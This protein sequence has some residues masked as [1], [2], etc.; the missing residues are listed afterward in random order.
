MS[1]RILS[2]FHSNSVSRLLLNVTQTSCSHFLQPTRNQNTDNNPFITPCESNV[3]NQ[4]SLPGIKVHDFRLLGFKPEII[5]RA[6]SINKCQRLSTSEQT[7]TFDFFILIEAFILHIRKYFI[8]IY[9]FSL[10][11]VFLFIS[12]KT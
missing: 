12:N 4:F 5:I 7:M 10:L 8:Q 6:E 9:N 2:H 1:F 3:D 11:F